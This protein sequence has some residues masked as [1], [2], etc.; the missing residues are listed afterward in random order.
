MSVKDRMK[1]VLSIVLTLCMV[2]SYI[3]APAYAA[4][5]DNLCDH[6]P[7]H[8]PECG[9]AEAVE[10]QPCAHVH[11]EL[12]GYIEAVAEVKCA[13][14]ATD[15]NGALVHTEG[16]GY[17]A[18]VE[19]SACAHVHDEACGYVAAVEAHECHYECA[20]CA[21]SNVIANQSADWC[22]NPLCSQE[23]AF[24]VTSCAQYV[25]PEN[26][27][28][29]CVEKCAEPNIWCDVCGFDYSKCTGIDRA[30][31]YDTGWEIV[32]GVL[33]VTGNLT[34]LPDKEYSSIKVHEGG[35]LDLGEAEATCDVVN[36]GTISSGR[37]IYFD[38]HNCGTISSGVFENDVVNDGMISGGTFTGYVSND[39]TITDVTF[40]HA[41]V[42]NSERGTIRNAKFD[43]HASLESGSKN[44]ES[45]I[46]SVNG[47][48][49]AL[50]YNA[51]L[52]AALGDA[53]AWYQGD[54]QVTGGSVPLNYTTYVG[55]YAVNTAA[56]TNGTVS[57]DPATAKFG[58]TVTITTTPANGYLLEKL[59]VM[60]GDTEVEVSSNTFTM[61]AGAVTVSATFTLCDH[62]ESTHE[63]A[64]DVGEGK[65]SFICTVCGSTGSA[66][67][68]GGTATCKEQ[69]KC[70]HCG[71]SYGELGN[72]S[73]TT[74]S[75]TVCGV[76]AVIKVVKDG[77]TTYY[78]AFSD[79][80]I[81]KS[82]VYPLADYDGD[83]TIPLGTSFYGEDY[84]FAGT[85]TNWGEIRSGTFTGAVTHKGSD[86]TG[87]TFKGT[88][89]ADSVINGGDFY[90]EVTTNS[91]IRGGIFHG[92][93]TNKLYITGG[94]FNGTVTNNNSIMGGIFNGTVINNGT[95]DKG[96][97]NDSV[98]N[99][100]TFNN[101][102]K[103]DITL[104][105]NFSITNNEGGKI[106]CTE[107][108]E[109][110]AANC[111]AKA[112]C[113]LCGEY[114][115]KDRYNHAK[116]T[117]TNGFWDCCGQYQAATLNADGY[118]EI[119]NAGKLFWFAWKV[120][121]GNT[122]FNGK[123]TADI[124]LENR[125]WT[126][127]GNNSNLY[128]GT[129]DGNGMTISRLHFDDE[130]A[131]VVGLFGVV[132]TNGQVKA[133]TLTDSSITGY[134]Y[135]G[136][137]AGENYGI[138]TGCV[139]KAVVSGEYSVGG[140]AGGNF[141]TVELCGNINR[142]TAGSYEAGGI[143]GRNNAT[144]R[145]CYNTGD[146]YAGDISAGGIAGLNN[147]TVA[148]SWSTGTVT[149]ET[150]YEGGITGE[151]MDTVQYCYST[152]S[153]IGR[154]GSG[155]IYNN[156][157]IRTTE[158]FESGEVA[159]I[160]GSV[161]GQTIGTDAYP[162]LGGEKVYYGYASCADDAKMVYT[163][164][165]SASETKPAH[166]GTLSCKDN[167]DGTHT[168]TYSCCNDTV[169][170]NHIYTLTAAGNVITSAC[171]A[172]C[173]CTG[174]AT[175]TAAG[176]TYDGHAADAKVTTEGN[177]ANATLRIDYA[178]KGG[179]ALQSAPANA[180]TY[181]ASI[182]MGENENA[183]VAS[184]EFTIAKAMPTFAAP[185][186]LTATYGDTLAS[187]ILNTA[188][189]ETAGTWAWN[190]ALTT[191]VGN[192]GKNTFKATF[193]PNDTANYNTAEADITIAVAKAAPA[194]TA[195][196]AMERLTYNAQAQALVTAGSTTGGTMMYRVGEG[197][198]SE[199]LPMA[200]NAG[201]HTVSY[202]VVGGANYNDVTEKSVTVTIAPMNLAGATVTL[203]ETSFVYDGQSH[204]PAV[205]VTL[206]GFGKLVEGKDYRVFY[207]GVRKMA[208]GK[209]I[210]WFGD[211]VNS[212]DCINA[213]NA[214]YAVVIGLGNFYTADAFTL[215]ENFVIRPKELT[216]LTFDGLDAW[217]LHTGEAI[218]PEFTLK[219]GA[220]ELTEDTDYTAVIENNVDIGTATITVTLKG[221]Y[222]G[223]VTKT[224]EIKTHVHEWSYSADGTTI[225]ATCEG[226]IGTCSVENK[227]VTIQ[228]AAPENL[229][230]D[231][232]TK[233]VTVT[234]T[235]AG[236]FTDIPAVTYEGN[237]TDAG[238]HTASLTY[239][240]VTAKLSFT[241]A[242]K[243]LLVNSVVV[244][245][246]IYDGSTAATVT[247][248]TFAGM[249]S[250]DVLLMGTD[251]TA[252]A[253]FDDANAGTDKTVTVTVMLKDTAV[254]K[255][256]RLVS[257]TAVA[258]ATISPKT[259]TD[260]DVAMNGTLIYTGKEQTQQV[261]VTEGITCEVSGNKAT[262]AGGYEL[263]VKGTGNYTGSVTLDWTIAK[264]KLT[265]TAD[266][267]VIYTGEKLP[268]LTYTVTGLVGG[269]KLVKEP[270]L[271]TGADA[272]QAGSYTITAANADAGDNYTITYVSGSLTVMDKE[273]EV[274]TKIELTELTQ[275]PDGLKDTRFNTV[276]KITEELIRKILA[277]S[278]GYSGSNVV[279]YDVALHF[280]LDGGD[281]W[282]MAT[283]ENFPTEGITVVL[284]YP[285]GTNP[286]DYDFVVS[287]MFTVTSQRLGTVA[288][289]VE[290]PE[291]EE[292]ANGI[293]VTLNGLSPVTVAARYHDHTGGTATC[294]EKAVCTICGN[295]YGEVD[296]TNHAGGIEVKNAKEATCGAEGYTGDTH[297][298]GCG[299]IVEKGTAI[300][301][302]GEHTYGNWKVVKKATQTEKGEKQRTCSACGHV[303][304]EEI[305]MI[306][307]IPA[308]GDD[309]NIM[310]H[311][312]MFTVSLAGLV[313]LLLAAKKRKQETA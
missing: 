7:E 85:V 77:V 19:G 290:M 293:R 36:Y 268:T 11:D 234:Q 231:G 67:H 184:V 38:V 264:A 193:T 146:I 153:P 200:T 197:E 244:A 45:V 5:A 134:D 205:T 222:S 84:T 292:T 98:T 123:L 82:D 309:F 246:K 287:H 236:V 53:N 109:K 130:T 126:P 204:Y 37:F 214:Y 26:P 259:I 63:T 15:E 56:A 143:A 186:G 169:T 25:A 148:Y 30:V 243:T 171:S 242:Q 80:L 122:E 297:C 154:Y 172:N 251:F 133:V 156:V 1:K 312:S 213:G 116:T 51:D 179:A 282:I 68:I 20:E 139:N 40:L 93:V 272:D 132:G 129:F 295:A 273:T 83:F 14:E 185:V 140:I 127:I 210:Q 162:V 4:G 89:T 13:C 174:T 249:E 107:H 106:D 180:G 105:E 8:T 70:E 97:F 284:P 310:L 69:A 176:K 302:T 57:V 138:I 35:N 96:V 76:K 27:K 178:V 221:N 206:D 124:N 90:G 100:G 149:A 202:K 9:Y 117:C 183:V 275:V 50:T 286:R 118:Y 189:G 303:D 209:P 18:P 285:A 280:S 166:T 263:T 288:G 101:K 144:I 248:V 308:T 256:Y 131:K 304:S 188:P 41:N 187:V 278:T 218:A 28:C 306:T 65:H 21:D 253:V 62:S 192:A 120:N 55:E 86:I 73:F 75:C 198:W 145:N 196:A 87:G 262:N 270:A 136:G 24:H 48:D 165:S 279:H 311:G 212:A 164:N 226:T 199:Q 276:E 159:Y 307:D 94:T 137:I 203:S 104:G 224:F 17:V 43:T 108:F 207:S 257:A 232:T 81:E 79:G 230:Y 252:A 142:I 215:Y 181:T 260:S 95:I 158:Q 233:T 235:P 103:G 147:G 217:Y 33:N 155:A 239:N 74:G 6:H 228:L 245:D 211:H 161:W 151:N 44:P 88:V 173:G 177:L 241:I 46:H 59:T 32:G 110:T 175:I 313:V 168:G 115:E 305:P 34:E 66:A 42:S 216:E 113:R 10:G 47:E 91:T 274:E 163:N 29:Y 250:T 119:D 167:G 247:E 225:T 128:T 52:P 265:I 121:V 267:K 219:D 269:D 125:A 254:A 258:T 2:F 22:G 170:G 227:T 72:H 31:G 61:P 237:C 141:G 201:D 92:A 298:K 271:T 266:S 39:G 208:N 223:T 60:N 58:Q 3:P 240:G 229:V 195:P 99:N 220:T 277:T 102:S 157:D 111:V 238:E 23:D 283:E 190:D 261:T 300:K 301:A 150:K 281:S 54:T 49:V 114:G 12:C 191:S 16:C 291:V 64:T 160:L 152:Q 135:V 182:G 71:A 299:E 255:N 194:V 289:E 112:V 78:T 294:T 296:K